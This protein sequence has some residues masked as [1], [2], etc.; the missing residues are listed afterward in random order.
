M[1][2]WSMTVH[3]KTILREAPKRYAKKSEYRKKIIIALILA[4]QI[5][6]FLLCM[7][8]IANHVAAPVQVNRG[9]G[10]KVERYKSVTVCSGESL[11]EISRRYYTDE[12]GSMEVYIKRI[13]KLNDMQDEKI[14]TGA[15]L[16]IPY[17]E[18][19]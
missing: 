15:C 14:H 18:P 7:A 19:P 11:W 4:L 1:A 17:Y 9:K 5:S 6:F 2:N 8:M 13:M 16:V 12:C 10:E 3:G